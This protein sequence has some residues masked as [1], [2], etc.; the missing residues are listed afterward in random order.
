MDSDRPRDDSDE[1]HVGGVLSFVE[2]NGHLVTL[3]NHMVRIIS[4]PRPTKR[5][6]RGGEDAL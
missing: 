6:E 2:V 5:T 1:S 3:T 4:G